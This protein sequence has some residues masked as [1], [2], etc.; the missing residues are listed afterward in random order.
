MVYGKI[1]IRE[2]KSMNS[3]SEMACFESCGYVKWFGCVTFLQNEMPKA[4]G[5]VDSEIMS[6]ILLM[7]V[8]CMSVS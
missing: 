7:I 5:N 2:S 1:L 8:G 6:V 3:R 4:F